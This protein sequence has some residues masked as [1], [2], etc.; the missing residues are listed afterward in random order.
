MMLAEGYSKATYTYKYQSGPP[1]QENIDESLTYNRIWNYD[2]YYYTATYTE[3]YSFTSNPY[4]Y[5]L[6]ETG[7]FN[8]FGSFYGYGYDYTVKPPKQI[9]FQER[10]PVGKANNSVPQS[11]TSGA[12]VVALCDGSV[13][14]ISP[15]I[16]WDTW[17][18][19]CTPNSGDQLGSDW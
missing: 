12:L 17:N 2:P 19:A 5:T 16:S 18:A 11:C 13:R 3:T 15:G 6:T 14:F 8:T 1:Y 4:N 9:T 7:T 10:P